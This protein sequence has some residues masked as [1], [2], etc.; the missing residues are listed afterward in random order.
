MSKKKKSDFKMGRGH[1]HFFKT[2]MK[3]NSAS[4][5]REMKI[6]TTMKQH[7]L[8]KGYYQSDKIQQVLVSLWR[9]GNSPHASLMKMCTG[10]ATVGNRMTF[11]QKLKSRIAIGPSNSTSGQLSK[12]NENMNSER[13][14][15]LYVQTALFTI[16]K[17]W[18][19][20][21]R[22]INRQMDKEVASIYIHTHGIYLHKKE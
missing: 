9:K 11:P 13:Y 19:Q 17:I 4:L 10:A 15:R 21:K 22:S 5:I 8:Q 7:L 14:L 16:A 6:K 2:N 3:R 1:R 12:G 18:K 20:P